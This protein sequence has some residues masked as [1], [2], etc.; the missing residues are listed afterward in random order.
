MTQVLFAVGFMFLAILIFAGGLHFSQYK[1]REN[2]GCCGGGHCSSDGDS[3]S[4]Y[5]SKT[6]FV[7]NINKIKA[8][9]LEAR[10]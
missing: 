9:K 7:D 6:D 10:G 5:S 2:G 4:C 1:K 3:H 8:E